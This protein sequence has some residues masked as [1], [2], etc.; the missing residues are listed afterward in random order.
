MSAI[1]ALQYWIILFLL[2]GLAATRRYVSRY[3][4]S[5]IAFAI[6]RYFLRAVI[7]QME[8]TGDHTF[9][10]AIATDWLILGINFVVIGVLFY[11]MV[12]G[13]KCWRVWKLEKR[14]RH[15]QLKN[16]IE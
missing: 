16:A 4:I 10:T 14:K 12:T 1:F 6:A 5:A 8:G 15:R 3:V 13:T 2:C 9:S 11:E 7:F